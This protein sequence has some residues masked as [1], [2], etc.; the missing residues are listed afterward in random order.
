MDIEVEMTDE[1]WDNLGFV[2]KDVL[3]SGYWFVI[4]L[5]IQQAWD[6]CASVETEPKDIV[7]EYDCPEQ[8]EDET[9]SDRNIRCHRTLHENLCRNRVL[10]Y[11]AQLR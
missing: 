10:N 11:F 3:E 6:V 5:D 2:A 4:C 8:T 1:M 7:P 9:E